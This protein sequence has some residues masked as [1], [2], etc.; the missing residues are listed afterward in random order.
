V[1]SDYVRNDDLRI[2]AG[3]DRPITWPLRAA[4]G[5]GPVDLSGYT[6]RAQV[7]ATPDAAAVLHEWS[8][9]NGNVL[10]A[11]S[12][13]SL[14]V[15]D[16]AAWTWTDGVYDLHLIDSVGRHEIVAWGRVTVL[17]GVTR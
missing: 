16:S 2:Y 8:A 6:A 7:R 13:V 15:D 17:P 5:G 4:L 12:A 14:L 1:F 3:D 9:G 10:L 11:A